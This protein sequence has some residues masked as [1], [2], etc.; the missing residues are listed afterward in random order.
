MLGML[1]GRERKRE[2]EAE[3]AVML[4]PLGLSG[5]RGIPHLIMIDST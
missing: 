3:P 5:D 4:N 1:R 2:G